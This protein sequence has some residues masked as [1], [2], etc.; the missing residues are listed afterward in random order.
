MSFVVPKGIFLKKNL[1]LW[2]NLFFI[3]LFLMLLVLLITAYNGDE[4]F[5]KVFKEKLTK[6]FLQITC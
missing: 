1:C 6:G 4:F 3:A 5:W 2:V